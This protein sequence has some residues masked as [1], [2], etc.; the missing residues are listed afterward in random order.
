M[1]MPG[2]TGSKSQQR[3]QSQADAIVQLLH[4]CALRDQD[5]TND[6]KFSQAD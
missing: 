1:L 4:F 5:Q 2:N 3:G 6:S